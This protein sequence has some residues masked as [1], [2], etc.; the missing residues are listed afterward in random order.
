MLKRS[1]LTQD[2]A[3]VSS[4]LRRVAEIGL[5]AL[6]DLHEHRSVDADSKKQSIEYLESSAKPQAVLL[7]MPASSVEK[8]VKACKTE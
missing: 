4:T 5:Q 8:L 3:P 1:F 7:L 2:L 6:D